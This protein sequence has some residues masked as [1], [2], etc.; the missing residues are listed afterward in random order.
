[1]VYD[2]VVERRR[3]VAVARRFREAEGLSIAQ[4]AA[5]LSRSGATTKAS[6]GKGDA[7]RYASDVIGG[8]VERS[9]RRSWGSAA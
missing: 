2:R 5:R 4:I 3:A 1:L 9:G 6:N 8:A 7:Y